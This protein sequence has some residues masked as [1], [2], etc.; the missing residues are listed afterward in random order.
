MCDFARIRT[1]NN[2]AAGSP[3]KSI[4]ILSISSKRKSG[5]LTPTLD[6]FEEFFQALNQYKFFYA[7]LF[8]I[9]LTPPRDIL[10]NFLPVDF[11]ID[12]PR[13]VFPTPGGPTRHK[14]G[15]FIFDTLC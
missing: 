14:T 15:P 1:S 2:A 8:L 12:S 3:R 7:L 9:H 10:T 5:F 6:I 4:P 13:E 11:A